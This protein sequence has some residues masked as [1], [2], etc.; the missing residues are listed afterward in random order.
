VAQPIQRNRKA[1]PLKYG[2]NNV[3]V[4]SGMTGDVLRIAASK[5]E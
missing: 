4:K 5:K 1:F 3:F 2:K